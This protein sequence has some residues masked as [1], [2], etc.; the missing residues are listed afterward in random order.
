MH[1]E[2]NYRHHR[3]SRCPRLSRPL[4]PRHARHRSNLPLRA[5]PPWLPTAL[6]PAGGLSTQSQ[7]ARRRRRG[8]TSFRGRPCRDDRGGPRGIR[9][10]AGA[11]RQARQHSSSADPFRA[12][13][14]LQSH[15]PAAPLPGP[16]ISCRPAWLHQAPAGVCSL[17]GSFES[18]GGYQQPVCTLHVADSIE[19]KL[20]RRAV[21]RTA[22]HNGCRS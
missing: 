17:R 22:G 21:S 20:L 6:C 4:H 16:A 5:S 19:W 12:S 18:C 14:A 2:K 3:Q 8:D 10:G 15:C 7:Q 13:L 9:Q 1:C 11:R